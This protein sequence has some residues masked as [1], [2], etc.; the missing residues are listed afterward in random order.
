M[1]LWLEAAIHE[2]SGDWFPAN[3]NARWNRSL[4]SCS[5]FLFILN[6]TTMKNF[7]KTLSAVA[8]VVFLSAVVCVTAQECYTPLEWIPKNYVTNLDR[9]KNFVDDEIEKMST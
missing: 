5:I 2:R 3:L 6:H 1:L 7:A 4:Q 8:A 9:N